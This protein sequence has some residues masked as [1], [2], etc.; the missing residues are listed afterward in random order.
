MKLLIISSFFPPAWDW[1]GPVRSMWNLARGLAGLGV[2]VTVL[3]TNAKQKGIVDVPPERVEEGVRIITAPVLGGGRSARLNRA[4][5]SPVHWKNIAEYVPRAEIVHINGVW[6][7]APNL[8]ASLC[9]LF[10]KPCVMSTRGNLDKWS[11]AQNRLKKALFLNTLGRTALTQATA[12]H[13]TVEEEKR[14]APRWLVRDKGIVVPNPVELGEPGNPERFR[15]TI[16]VTDG[17]LVAGIFGRIHKKK[18]FD[19]II[20]ALGKCRRSD[21]VL[22]AAG[23]DEGGYKAE[24][25]RMIRDARVESRVFFAGMLSG[26]D[27]ADAYA[28]ID[29]LVVPSYEENFGNVVVEAAAQGTPCFVSDQVGLKDWVAGNDIGLVLPLEPSSWAEALDGLDRAEI[30]KR[31]EPDR[32]SHLARESFSIDAVARQMLEQYERLLERRRNP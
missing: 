12:F 9:R 19:V 13:F 25:E 22:V 17:T 7:P 29:A 28:G 11:L 8:A 23:P 20:P 1:G 16:G 2:E 6:G 31:W 4:G 10:R 3:A 5:V 26:R 21:L 18:G 15:Q 27:L 14:Q 24:V 32:I 30:P